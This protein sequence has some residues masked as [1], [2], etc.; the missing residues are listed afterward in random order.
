MPRRSF[1]A[2]VI[3]VATCVAFAM[4]SR[5][6]S[7]A[8]PRP[9]QPSAA[10]LAM[11]EAMNAIVP[12]D[13]QI[14]VAASS[15]CEL[16]KLPMSIADLLPLL[17]PEHRPLIEE[18][19]RGGMHVQRRLVAFDP[20]DLLDEPSGGDERSATIRDFFSGRPVD[21][22]TGTGSSEG[23]YPISF[24]WAVVLDPRSQTLFSFVLNCRD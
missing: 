2:T 15:P 8:G 6:E 16:E 1:F 18:C 14:V 17:P 19:A 5:R 3:S 21:V 11:V 12:S 4:S 10:A 20:L 7:E 23:P 13:I 24:D 9:T 22:A